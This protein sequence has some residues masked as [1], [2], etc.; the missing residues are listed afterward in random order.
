ML[1]DVAV[2]VNPLDER[3][4]HLHRQNAEAAAHRPRNSRHR[5]RVGQIRL[6]HRRGQG[7]ACPRRQRLCD[8]PE[9]QSAVDLGHGRDRAHE[10]PKPALPTPGLTATMLGKKFS[11]TLKPRVSSAQVRDHVNAIGKCARCQTIVEPRLSTQWF[12]AVNKTPNKGGDSM[13]EM[14]RKAVQEAHAGDPKSKP[15]RFTPENYEKIYLEWMNN[16][17]DW[18]ISRQLWWGHRIPA[19]HCAACQQITVGREDPTHCAHCG[20]AEITQETDVLDTWFSSGLLPVTVFG[21]PPPPGQSTPD[22]DAFYP[23]S[24]LVT[25]FDILFFWVARMIMLGCYFSQDVPMPDGARRSAQRNRALPRGL[26]SRAGPRRRP[27]ED[28]QDQRQRHRPR[29]DRR[30]VRDGRCAVHARLDGLARHGHRLQRSPHRRLSRLR[31]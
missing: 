22:L 23:T 20:S 25:G 19:W 12:V 5:R 11:T 2:A 3:Y 7:H 4:S 18:C 6:R 15:I 13:A 10:R 21:W 16:I 8:R 26:H 29:P 28:V 17:Y 1:G 31:Q 24:L 27:P 14:A 30:E 9:A